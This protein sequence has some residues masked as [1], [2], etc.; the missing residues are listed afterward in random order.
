M[1]LLVFIFPDYKDVHLIQ[2]QKNLALQTAGN[3]YQSIGM[4][5]KYV[6]LHCNL[7]WESAFQK[8]KTLFFP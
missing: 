5:P 2:T 8:C 1:G 6:Q 3:C 4:E 7:S